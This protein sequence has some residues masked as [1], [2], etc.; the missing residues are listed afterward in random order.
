MHQDSSK[1]SGS[2]SART[3]AASG[4][5]AP[6]TKSEE[7]A[8]DAETSS[9]DCSEGRSNVIE[10]DFQSCLSVRDKLKILAA[11]VSR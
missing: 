5:P 1:Y 7:P 8:R 4:P 10:V 11:R 9:T 3:P 6:G 2:C